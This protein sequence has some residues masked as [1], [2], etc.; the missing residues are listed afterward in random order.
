MENSITLSFSREF[1]KQYG[2]NAALVYK[3]IYRKYF[4][5]LGQGQLTDGFF[6][7]DQRVIAD[8]LLMSRQ[9]LNRV[10]NQ[11]KEAGLIETETHYKPG[12]S[13]TTTWWR[14]PNWESSKQQNVT[15]CGM[16]QNV[17]SYIKADTEAD[18]VKG[19]A[20]TDTEEGHMLPSALYSKLRSAFPGSSND[21]RK[22]KIEAVEKLQNEFELSDE[23]ILD[24]VKEISKHPIYK[25]DD[26][27]EFT[28]SLAS[29]LLG[30]LEKTAGKIIK[31]AEAARV[32]EEKKNKESSR[33]QSILNAGVC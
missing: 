13:E 32:R 12:T 18:T 6:W 17:T 16:S 11:L 2:M 14:I 3:E 20:E 9:T 23:T 30:D 19:I 24:G 21:M 29:L 4:Y 7:C 27:R 5:F 10:V 25:F 22:K 28:E 26:G 15:S 8:W 1:A 31:K 33:R